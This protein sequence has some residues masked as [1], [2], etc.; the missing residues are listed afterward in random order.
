MSS[1]I[2][3]DYKELNQIKIEL[4]KV[5]GQI[6][7]ATASALNRTLRYTF[8]HTDKE[9]RNLYAIKSKDVKSTMKK[10]LASKSNLYAYLSSTGST[11]NLT[12][13]PHR[14]RKFSKRNKKRMVQVKIKTNGGYKGINTTPKAFV[15]TIGG[16]T[17]IW[18]RKGKE[19]FPVTTLRTLSVPQMIKNEKISEKVQRLSNEKLEERIE[20]EI[21]WRLDK[22]SK[23]G[24]K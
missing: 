22:L 19:R 3:V 16:K 24:G 2:F 8:T 11:I 1:N 5:P 13:F 21:N 18:K 20:H 9:V 17:N 14:P 23:K 10:H 15:Q 7:G 6:P 12:K 4:G